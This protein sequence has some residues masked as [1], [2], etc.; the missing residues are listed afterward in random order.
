MA[1]V[2]IANNEKG[3][4]SI[5]SIVGTD[6]DGTKLTK[7]LFELSRTT[8]M[9]TKFDPSA[10]TREFIAA[11]SLSGHRAVTLLGQCDASE[12]P[13]DRYFRDSWTWSD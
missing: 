13:S 10:H 2:Y 9:D 3:G 8:D 11:G 4:I 6:A 7:M 5:I 1:D 12:I